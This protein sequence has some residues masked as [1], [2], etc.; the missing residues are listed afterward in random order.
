[1][2]FGIIYLVTNKINGKQYVG[3]TVGTVHKR[4]KNHFLSAAPEKGPTDFF[5]N[6]IR[7][8]GC[9]S[10]CIEEIDIAGSREELDNKEILHIRLR[11]TLAPCGYNLTSGGSGS[12]GFSLSSESRQRI[13]NTLREYEFTAE[14]RKSISEA[15]KGK[16]KPPKTPEHIQRH[17]DSLAGH[18]VPKEIRQKISSSMKGR[19]FSL[20]HRK[21]LSD[22]WEHR[23]GN[24]LPAK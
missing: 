24:I 11:N 9:E 8:Y 1:M 5:H 4:L 6:A 21:H 7:K 3:Q 17:A 22:A 20:E 18:V 12:S 14:H 15:N 23:R 2:P 19:K 13:A 16:R 10:F